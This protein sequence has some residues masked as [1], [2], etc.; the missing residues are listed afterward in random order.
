MP[1]AARYDAAPDVLLTDLG[2][3]EAC[4]LNTRTLYYYALN[5][6]GRAIWR[7]IAAGRTEGEAADAL[8]ETYDIDEAGAHAHVRAFLQAL[9][10]DDLIVRR[11]PG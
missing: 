4:L 9:L 1:D 6:T 11:G 3:T 8:T 2:E 7:E 10:D 5:E